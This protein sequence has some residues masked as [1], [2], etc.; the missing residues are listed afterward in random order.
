MK[1][2]QIIFTGGGGT[3]GH[4][5]VNLA[6]IP[7]FV[8]EGWTVDYIGSVNGIEK[9]LIEPLK[10]VTY[11]SIS[12][13][14]LR[15]YFSKENFKDPFKVVKG[16]WQAHRIIGKKKP[17]V[18]FSKGG[19]V[20]VPVLVAAR[21]KGVP[22]V[23]HES[24]YTPGLANKLAIPFA[25]KVLA[26]FPETLNYLPED[27]AEW[28]GAV[29][30]EELYTGQ[31]EKGFKL[32]GLN[33]TKNVLLIMGGSAGS[34]KINQA[35]RAGLDQL[36]EEFQVIHICGKDNVDESY[37]QPGYVQYEY[38]Q[39]ELKDILAITDLVCSRAGANSIFEFLA[40]NK[41]MLLIPL[42]RNASR[43]D[44]IVNADSFKK[45]GYAKVL[46]EEQ[47]TTETLRKALQQLKKDK[48][49]IKDKMNQY[50]SSEAKEKVME[51]IKQQATK[52]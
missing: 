50:R 43:G 47:L 45:Q 7:E 48:L 33:S 52:Q 32:T 41:P 27:K 36:L 19:F 49:Q 42:S 18:I 11:H 24:D 4:V 31:R 34:Q 3:A 26:T 40:L 30:R 17:A 12:T 2:K 1:D 5:M 6:I 22:A 44:Q 39:E 46:E 20:S 9:D 10:G 23:I 16:T 35:I 15:R 14:K 13:G 51:I 37:A 38:V 21:L 8:K 29:V 25:K 28:I